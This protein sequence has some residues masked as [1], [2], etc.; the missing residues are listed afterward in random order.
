MS[1]EYDIIWHEYE[2]WSIPYEEDILKK[3][4]IH[5]YMYARITSTSIAPK[6]CAIIK[7]P[8]KHK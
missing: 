7:S 4:N 6:K 5:G 3:Q 8:W 2:A 1:I